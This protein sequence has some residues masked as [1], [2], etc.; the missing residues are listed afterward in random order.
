MNKNIIGHPEGEV[1]EK[2]YL[3]LYNLS[4]AVL[5]DRML[6]EEAM[7]D[8]LLKYF[9]IQEKYGNIREPDKWL[10]TVCINRSIDM[11]RKRKANKMLFSDDLETLLGIEKV[12]Q[13]TQEHEEDS[14]FFLE[15]Q[16]ISLIKLKEAVLSMAPGYRLIITLIYYEGMDYEE[17]SLITGLKEATVRS[18]FL[19]AKKRLATIL[20]DYKKGY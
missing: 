20:K 12:E 1:Y 11:L 16:G 13:F 2:Y 3:R 15:M 17:I 14:Q 10:T 19:R 4:Y 6:A 8:T 5:K 7:H 9:E 18:Q